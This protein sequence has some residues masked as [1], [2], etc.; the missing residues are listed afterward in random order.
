MAR[1][2]SPL[3]RWMTREHTRLQSEFS[4]FGPDWIAVAERCA[5]EN[6]KDGLRGPPSAD[7]CRK[8]WWR[9]RTAIAA[10]TK[11]TG[12]V[13]PDAMAQPAMPVIRQIEPEPENDTPVPSKRS[14][15]ST[16]R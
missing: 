3:Y 13:Q 4:E 11:L 5:A 14:W 15:S 1:S 16:P 7:T 12:T 6:I 10:K 2:Y 8:T 9:V